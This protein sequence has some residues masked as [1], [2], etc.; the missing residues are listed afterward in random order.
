L[1]LKIGDFKTFHFCAG[2]YNNIVNILHKYVRV[3]QFMFGNFMN[4]N[5]RS[6]STYNIK[7]GYDETGKGKYHV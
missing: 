1:K 7:S 2:G 5:K 6:K 3:W 4:V